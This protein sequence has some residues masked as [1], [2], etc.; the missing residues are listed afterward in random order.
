MVK[1]HDAK[2]QPPSITPWQRVGSMHP[3]VSARSTQFPR[4]QS[5]ALIVSTP[6]GDTSTPSVLPARFPLSSHI[7]LRPRVRAASG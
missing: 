5:M 7:H 2:Q 1:L 4:M 6:L 3:K